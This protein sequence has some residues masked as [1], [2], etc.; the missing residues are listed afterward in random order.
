MSSTN[1]DNKYRVIKLLGE[2]GFGDVWLAEDNLID[3]RLVA[4]KVLKNINID[5]ISPLIEEMQYLSS[6]DHQ[7]IVK[8]LHH[9]DEDGKI[10]L[11]MEY[12]S[13]GNLSNFSSG[14][15]DTSQVFAWGKILAETF[16]EVHGKGIVHHDIKP[17]NLLIT[18][19]GKIKVTDF[20]VANRNWGTRVYMAPELFLAGE[21]AKK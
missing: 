14:E 2:G 1:L 13:G 11:V 17:Q 15:I 7:N 16:S 8:F 12:C 21:V 4:I 20:G 19:D 10:H 6:L 18:E 3:G 5:D 9:F